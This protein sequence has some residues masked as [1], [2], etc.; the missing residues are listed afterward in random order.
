MKRSIT[1]YKCSR[2]FFIK[3]TENEHGGWPFFPGGTGF[4]VNTEEETY[5]VTADHCLFK[6]GENKSFTRMS[7]ILVLLDWDDVRGEIASFTDYTY[8]NIQKKGM[9]G[10]PS[11]LE[12]NDFFL[13]RLSRDQR[14]RLKTAIPILGPGKLSTAAGRLHAGE[15]LEVYGFPFRPGILPYD[16]DGKCISVS[17]SAV[18]SEFQSM[19]SSSVGIGVAKIKGGSHRDGGE[20]KGELDGFSGSPIFLRQGT[21]RI[22]FAGIVITAG[23]SLIRFIHGQVIAQFIQNVGWE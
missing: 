13:L 23:G 5:F 2:Q 22:K 18:I 3:N 16:P 8:P 7:N 12:A 6:P 20:W 10:G 11:E 19:D 15:K 9:S 17:P 21:N 4:F 14:Q 1:A